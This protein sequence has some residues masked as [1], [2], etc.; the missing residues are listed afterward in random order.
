MT[1]FESWRSL[2][3]KYTPFGV[4]LEFPYGDNKRL[5]T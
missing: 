3:K 1:R 2:V 5:A 4:H